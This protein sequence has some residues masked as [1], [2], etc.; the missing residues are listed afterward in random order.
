VNHA[1]IARTLL[2]ILCGVQGAATLAIDLN[3]THATNPDWTRHARFH[4]VWQATSYALL[5]LLEAALV[6][7]PGPLTEQRFY[8]AA[9]LASIPVLGFFG[10]F[11]FRRIYGGSLF[12]P[13]GIH[14]LRIEVFGTKLQIDMNLAAEVMALLLLISI[15]A[16][17][18]N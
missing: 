1:T 11:I 8:L 6:L 7:A 2:A 5:S 18:R 16:L 9:L 15:V 13:N 17:F 10:A 4:I 3:R 12:D 14:P